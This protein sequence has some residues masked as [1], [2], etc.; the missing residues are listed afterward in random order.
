MILLKQIPF[1]LPV[2]LHDAEIPG[3]TFLEKVASRN[4]LL[5]D[6]ATLLA[7][8]LNQILECA[9]LLKKVAQ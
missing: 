1:Y 7:P 9:G 5:P 2:M 3:R 4:F 8:S 6:L